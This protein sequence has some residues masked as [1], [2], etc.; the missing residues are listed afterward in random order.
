M[1]A[2]WTEVCLVFPALAPCASTPTQLA[3]NLGALDVLIPDDALAS[4]EEASA[5]QLV[6]AVEVKSSL[7][8]GRTLQV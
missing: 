7:V 6:V 3:D 4:L 2:L 5:I 1:A 8:S